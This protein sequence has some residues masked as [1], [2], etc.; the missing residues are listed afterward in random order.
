M[1]QV[2]QE[3]IAITNYSRIFKTYIFSLH[4]DQFINVSMYPYSYQIYSWYICSGCWQ[5]LKAIWGGHKDDN[6][7]NAQRHSEAMIEDR[8]RCKWSPQ[9]GAFRDSLG[10]RKWV[11]CAMHLE[12]AIEGVWGG[13]WRPRSSGLRE[14]HGG[15][16]RVNLNIDSE[17]EMMWTQR[18]TRMQ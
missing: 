18:S 17:G 14:A 10:G 5:C 6:P 4:S 16:S 12:A 9:P 2:H 11:Q 15:H 1:L 7:V 3:I 8:C 13:I